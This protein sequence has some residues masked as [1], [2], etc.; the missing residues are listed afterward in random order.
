M[1]MQ[2]SLCIFFLFVTS[3]LFALD[4]EEVFAPALEIQEFVSDDLADDVTAVDMQ[5]L[6]LED[7][8]NEIAAL[9]GEEDLLAAVDNLGPAAAG[10]ASDGDFGPDGD[11]FLDPRVLRDFIESRGLIRCRQKEGALTIAGDVRAR[12]VSVGEQANGIKQ[13]GTGTNTAINRYKSEVNLFFDYSAPKGWVTTK[14]KWVNFDGKDGGTATK[15]D[16]ERAFIG[17]DIYHENPTD[18]YIEIG[19]SRF[20]YMYESRVEF[21]SIFDGIHLFYTT[22]WKGVGNFTLH[23][24][25]FI[26][27]SFTNHYGWIAETFVTRWRGTGFSFKYSIIDWH[28]HSPTLNYGNLNNSGTFT[29]EDNPRYRF[30]VSQILF[31]YQRKLE[32]AHCK[33]LYVYGAI[34][35]NHDAKRTVTT[36][37]KKLNNAWYT[38]FTLGKLCKAFDWS[39]DINYQSVQAQAVPEYDLAGIGHGNAANLLLSDAILQGFGSSNAIGFTNYKGWQASLLYAMTDSLSLRAQAARTVPRNKSVG[40]DF[41]YKSFE[42]SVIYAF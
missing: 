7:L 20:D 14:L 18:F 15:S 22:D 28:R 19:R 16:M 12:W 1:G 32:L 27:D 25:P 35:A 23:G 5:E 41:R 21:T 4:E 26:V 2:K 38:G 13:R 3:F 40:Q 42:M 6:I 37:F 29:V 17:Y 30:I 33:S 31:G 11:N 24:G 36:G 39:I 34:L 9:D 8:S 10:F